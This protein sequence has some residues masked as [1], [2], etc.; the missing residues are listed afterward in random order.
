[1]QKSNV[2]LR[3]FVPTDENAPETIHPTMRTFNDPASGAFACFR[4]DF[5]RFLVARANMRGETKFCNSLVR[6]GIIVTSIQTEV[7]QRCWRR[8]RTFDHNVVHGF[9]K[10]FFVMAIGPVYRQAK[11]NAMP[12][13]QQATLYAAFSAVCRIRADFFPRP[14]GLW[15]SHHLG[16]ATPIQCLLVRRIARHLLAIV[17][18]RRRLLPT[19]E[20]DHEPSI[21]RTIQSG[22]AIPIDLP[23]AAHRRSHPHSADRGLGDAH[24]Q[25]GA[26]SGA[27]A[28]WVP[29]LPTTRLIHGTLLWFGSWRL[30]CVF[31]L[32]LFRF[33]F[34]EF[35]TGLFG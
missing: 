1:M 34:P 13:G 8:R 11:R 28:G 24:R 25:S 4:F 31:V 14:V 35:T 7:L 21:W 27:A 29:V 3:L 9:C 12:F 5:L 30:L 32:G 6:I 23:F 18:G 15:S 17:S 2:I 20:T 16:L 19:L 22:S 33:S 26:Y 10:Q